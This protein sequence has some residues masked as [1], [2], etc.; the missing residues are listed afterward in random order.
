M[1]KIKHTLRLHDV[2]K[3][4]IARSLSIAHSTV[5]NRAEAAN[6]TWPLSENLSETG[7]RRSFT[8]V[9]AAK[10]VLFGQNPIW[11]YV[12]ISAAQIFMA[13]LGASNYT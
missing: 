7:W 13:V 3:R 9:Y 5:T 11:S 12:V 8:R 6:L 10:I 1:R 4:Q 2:G